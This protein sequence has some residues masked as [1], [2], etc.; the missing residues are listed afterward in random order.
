[1]NPDTW[2]RLKSLPAATGR[3]IKGGPRNDIAPP[4]P[5]PR[6]FWWAGKRN[7]ARTAATKAAIRK[8]KA[9]RSAPYAKR[10]ARSARARA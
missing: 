5:E 9:K 7:A 10:L 2:T 4:A 6:P 8:R 3:W 1:M